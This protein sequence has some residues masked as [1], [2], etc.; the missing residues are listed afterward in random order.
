[1]W[2]DTGSGSVSSIPTGFSP[3]DD[4]YDTNR[5]LDCFCHIKPQKRTYRIS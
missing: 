2:M 4:Y 1:M 5:I 3:I